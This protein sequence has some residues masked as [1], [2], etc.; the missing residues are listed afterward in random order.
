MKSFGIALNGVALPDLPAACRIERGE[1]AAEAAAG[2]F[3]VVAGALFVRGDRYVEAILE[4]LQRAGDHCQRMLVHAARPDRLARTC[5]ERLRRDAG[6]KSKRTK[7]LD[8]SHP[9][10]TDEQNL[11]VRPDQSTRESDRR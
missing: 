9:K 4:E 3:L 10:K 6:S 5:I 8:I 2:V 11:D 1:A 7:R